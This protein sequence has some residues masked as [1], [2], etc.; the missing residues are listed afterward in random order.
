MYNIAIPSH[1]RSQIIKK[2][3]LRFLQKHN[4]PKSDIYIFVTE[5]EIPAYE[6]SLDGYNICVGG[7]GIANQR[8]AISNFFD[9]DEFIVSIDDDLD[10]IYNFKKVKFLS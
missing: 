6:E 3:T 7:E 1:N 10:D 4:I 5:E 2:K 9:E 8:M